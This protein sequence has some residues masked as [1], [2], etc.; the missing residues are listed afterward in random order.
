MAVMLFAGVAR[1]GMRSFERRVAL[2]Q[3]NA[4]PSNLLSGEPVFPHERIYRETLGEHLDELRK[5]LVRSTVAILVFFCIAWAFRYPID[6]WV[7]RPYKDAASRLNAKLVV[8]AEE[9][10][11]RNRKATNT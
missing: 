1:E 3:R 9:A 4:Y 8:M 2:N 7:Q 5:R 6:D 11:R 10:R